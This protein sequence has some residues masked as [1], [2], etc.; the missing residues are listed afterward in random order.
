MKRFP[1][2]LF[3]A[4]AALAGPWQCLV[5]QNEFTRLAPG[6][7]RGALQLEPVVYPTTK[8]DSVFILYDA[9]IPGELPFNFEVTYL[10][11][12]RFVVD[13]LNGSERIRIDSITYGRDRQTARDTINLYFPEYQS[14]LHADVRGGALQGEWVVTT[15]RNYRIPFSAQA[16]KNYRF[17]NLQQP[18]VADISGNW[19]ALFGID[20]P[21]TEKALGEF[22]QQNNRLLGTFRT[23]TGDYRFLEGT[24]QGRKFWLSA[25]DGAHAFLFTGNIGR[26]SLQGEFRSGTHSKTLWQA[27]R[28]PA[29]QLG[30]PD[31]LTALKPSAT[32]LSFRLPATGGGD[33]TFPGPTFDGKVKVFTIMGTWCPNC[34]D[35]QA[36]LSEFLRQYPDLAAQTACVG[37]A[38]ERAL[39][40]TRVMPHLENYR[41]RMNLPFPI[42]YAG[43]A[44]TTEAQKVFPGL[45]KVMAFPTMIV[46]DKQNRVRRI[47]TGFDG[48]ATS[49][50]NDFKKDF[51]TL[52]RQLVAEPL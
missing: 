6:I 25:F 51:E 20:K 14:Y 41:Q 28:D 2:V 23:E 21:E 37:F 13:I 17:T 30:N 44:S 29:F 12:E 49:K 33:L 50:Y 10:D 43:K 32:T 7:W 46:L 38:F 48:P 19:A 11:R 3:A 27:W 8:R 34:R 36:F 9:F 40:S 39:D 42:V 45:T 1:L 47:H 26:D 31:S 15:K 22:Q 5:P 16:G 35:E 4:I 52:L 18:P 24:V